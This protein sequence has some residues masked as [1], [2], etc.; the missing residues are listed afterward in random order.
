MVPELSR[1]VALS[2]NERDGPI[3]YF[4]AG[5]HT[6]PP[7]LDEQAEMAFCMASVSRVTLSPVLK[8]VMSSMSPESNGLLA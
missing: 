7:P 4:P 3:W 5:T 1:G 8:L 2:D 6:V